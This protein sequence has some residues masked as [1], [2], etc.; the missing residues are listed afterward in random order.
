MTWRGSTISPVQYDSSPFRASLLI[1]VLFTSIQSS[2]SYT[3]HLL[4]LSYSFHAPPLS[5]HLILHL[6]LLLIFLLFYHPSPTTHIY[7]SSQVDIQNAAV[8][9]VQALMEDSREQLDG[10]YGEC[11]ICFDVMEKPYRCVTLLPNKTNNQTEQLVS[12]L[13]ALS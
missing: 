12:I 4:P 1:I 5:L 8:L 2:S 10:G 13:G 6:L 3:P 11:P 9:A 7:H